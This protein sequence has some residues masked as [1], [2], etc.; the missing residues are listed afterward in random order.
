MNEK[1]GVMPIRQLLIRMSLPIMIAMLIQALY[2]IVDGI[3]VA[4]YSSD[5]LSAVSVAFPI[6]MIIIAISV[7]TAIGMNAVLA[8]KLGEKDYHAASNIALHGILLA[9]VSG[10]LLAIFGIFFAE[11]FSNIFSSDPEVVQMSIIYIRICTVLSFGVFVQIALERIMQATG[12]TVY[13]MVM[14]GTGAIINIVLDPIM[15]FGLFGCPEMGIA[16]A[17]IATVIGQLAAMTIGLIIVKKKIKFINLSIAEFKFDKAVIKQIYAVGFPA[18]IMQSLGS[19]MTL[20]LNLILATHSDTAISVFSIYAKLQQFIFMPVFGMNNAL[21][22]IVAYNYGAKNKGRILDVVKV[23]LIISSGIMLVGTIL[24]Q[25][26]SGVIL[27]VFLAD[28]KM[29]EIGIPSLKI[30]SL[31]FVFAGISVVL[32]GVFQALGRG[33][34]SLSV[35]LGRQIIILLPLAYVLYQSNGIIGIWWSFVITEAICTIY[36]IIM[37][38]S[39][40]KNVIEQI[41]CE[42]FI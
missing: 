34:V 15:I 8:R 28:A 25:L 14:L 18:I 40:K 27:D 19:V 1:M 41:D 17:A 23:G 13:N 12:L 42:A 22:A 20:G 21:V 11:P 10:L 6:S 5:A 32:C 4:Q 3:F 30:I 35:S 31:S 7:G 39:L 36:S 16:G 33:F 9:L 2:N 38:R 24:F 37:M 29:L 26:A